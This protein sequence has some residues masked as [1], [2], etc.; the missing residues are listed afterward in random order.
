MDSG[1]YSGTTNITLNAKTDVK[2]NNCVLDN[3]TG[4]MWSRYVSASVGPG[5]DGKLPWTTNV[6]GEGI[7]AYADAANAA[8]LAG[9]DDWR[10]GNLV[11]LQSLVMVNPG[12]GVPDT[13]A[14]PGWPTTGL[15]LLNCY[16]A[17]LLEERK[18]IDDKASFKAKR[19]NCCFY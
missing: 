12:S 2:S 15:I 18:I 19:E 16:I 6:D 7:F 14:F 1:Q 13:T 9:Y 4:L 8:S 10:V 3:N 17:S 5:S 11:E